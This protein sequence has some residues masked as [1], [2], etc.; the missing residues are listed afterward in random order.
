MEV[1]VPLEE[2]PAVAAAAAAAAVVAQ[3]CSASLEALSVEAVA[4][5]AV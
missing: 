5:V 3:Q 4:A 2:G 1:L